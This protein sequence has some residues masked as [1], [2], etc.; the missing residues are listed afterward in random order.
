M[1]EQPKKKK[2]TTT[3]NLSKN[4]ISAQTKKSMKTRVITSIVLAGIYVPAIFIG[5]WFFLSVVFLTL[6]VAATEFVRATKIPRKYWFIYVLT[7]VVTMLFAFWFFIK[8]NLASAHAGNYP[9]WE[10]AKWDINYGFQTIEI[11]TMLLVF[12]IFSLFTVL[13]I[14]KDFNFAIAS[15]LFLLMLFVG[16]GIQSFLFLRFYPKTAN[17]TSVFLLLYI[18]LGTFAN[19]VGAYFVGVMY[20][21]TKMSPLLSPNKTWEGF[22]GGVFISFIISFVFALIV[23]FAGAP[24]IP[25]LDHTHWYWLVLLSLL[26]PIFA[27]VGDLFF[28][29]TKR[30]LQI[31]D[32]G[33]IIV[34]HGGVLD[35]I[36]SLILVSLLTSMLVILIENAWNL[37]T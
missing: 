27:N 17:V 5:G 30:H 32:Y 8:R 11:S 9:F 21:K 26:M 23:S 20:G 34:G 6:I 31:K 15:Y 37:L 7:T 19:D 13:V 33:S 25:S 22:V 35:R 3:L 16:L 12:V 24:I 36:D 18:M 2:W 10:L 29:A 14:D 28:S 4:E 1:M